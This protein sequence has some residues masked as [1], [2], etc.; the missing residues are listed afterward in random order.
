MAAARVVVQF[1][2]DSQETAEKRVPE[3]VERAKG[4]QQEPGC[5][6]FEVFRS[7]A[8]PQKWAL[9]ELWESQ[10]VLDERNKARGGVPPAPAGVNRV[11][12]HYQHHPDA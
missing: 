3:L 7:V 6:Q 2:A 10:Q 9:I 1:T 11:I 4:V 8:N 12:E 5:L